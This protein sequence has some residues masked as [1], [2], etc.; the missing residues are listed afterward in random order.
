MKSLIVVFLILLIQFSEQNYYP[1]PNHGSYLGSPINTYGPLDY[2]PINPALLP[3]IL[4]N[5]IQFWKVSQNGQPCPGKS[6][7][8]NIDGHFTMVNNVPITLSPSTEIPSE[9]A[10]AFNEGDHRKYQAP[11][12][13]MTINKLCSATLLPGQQDRYISWRGDRYRVAQLHAH[14]GPEGGEGGYHPINGHRYPLEIHIVL[15][16][17]KWGSLLNAL[18]YDD[19]VLLLCTLY[20]VS[21]VELYQLN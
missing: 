11:S 1:D 7:P 15:F 4:S 5:T 2:N 19:G 3:L 6:S 13:T 8:I 16:Q 21:L 14:Y 18:N 9:S 12:S 17:D 10:V 20:Q